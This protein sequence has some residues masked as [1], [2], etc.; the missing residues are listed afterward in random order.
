MKIRFIIIGALV[1]I[2]II[3]FFASE[4]PGCPPGK[5]EKVQYFNIS[6]S[7]SSEALDSLKIKFNESWPVQNS[8]INDIEYKEITSDIYGWVVKND[9]AIDKNSNIY[10]RL[11]C[12]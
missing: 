12:L 10:V 9:F 3:L 1:I 5:F 11:P 8:T 6:I 7:N 2:F 4:P